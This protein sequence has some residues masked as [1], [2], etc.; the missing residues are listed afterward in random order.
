MKKVTS[1]D[2]ITSDLA[3]RKHIEED[4]VVEYH[5]NQDS[6]LLELFKNDAFSVEAEIKAGSSGEG[7]RKQ[8]TIHNNCDKTPYL[9]LF[10]NNLIRNMLFLQKKKHLKFR[11]YWSEF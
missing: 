7:S 2:W 9:L 11:K 5:M 4:S 10:Q 1:L 3:G 6:K 8:R